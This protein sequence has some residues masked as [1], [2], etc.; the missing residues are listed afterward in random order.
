MESVQRSTGGGGPKFFSAPETAHQ[1]SLRPDAQF[2]WLVGVFAR[3]QPSEPSSHLVRGVPTDGAG[4]EDRSKQFRKYLGGGRGMRL[5]YPIALLVAFTTPNWAAASQSVNIPNFHQVD[6]HVYRGAQPNAQ[7]WK[8]LAR[9]GIKLVLDLRPDGELQEHRTRSEQ[10]AVEAAGMRYMSLPMDGSAM[11]Q[12]KQ[13]SRAL[14]ILRSGEFV[15]VHCRGGRNRTGTVI[16]CYRI[17]QDHWTNEQALAEAKANG[18]NPLEA[19]M[20]QYIL[21]F[22][23]AITR[24]RQQPTCLGQIHGSVSK[25]NLTLERCQIRAKAGSKGL[26]L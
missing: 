21:G 10:E 22:P 14:A 24:G 20:Q 9:L 6:D 8:E 19:A 4:T 12:D 5:L 1:A 23:A 17:A 13:I 2:P 26:A 11:P 16:A 18:M 3:R 25:R 7:G 15:F